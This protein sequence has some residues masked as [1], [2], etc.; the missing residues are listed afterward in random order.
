MVSN[1]QN[2]IK[3]Y[4]HEVKYYIN[5]KSAYELSNILRC[6]MKPDVHNSIDGSYWIRSLYFDTF[7]NIDYYD[8]TIGVSS[9]KKIRLRIYNTSENKVKLEIKNKN[10]LYILKETATISKEDAN[11]LISGNSNPLLKYNSNTSTR[12]FYMMNKNLY[13]PTIM[14][15]YEREAY[16]YQFENIRVTFDKN[17]R[18]SCNN[19][20]L[21]SSEIN[22]MP[23]L[24]PNIFVLEIKYDHTLPS[25]LQKILSPYT[26]DRTSI[27]KYCLGRKSYGK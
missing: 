21:F 10:G 18:V 14:V 24:N 5:K 11:F 26:L 16:T 22:M 15:D 27:S 7:S 9:R 23:V 19:F 20:N 2:D 6:C 12:V 4:R 25:F 8:K 3:M 1:L 13:R 17:I